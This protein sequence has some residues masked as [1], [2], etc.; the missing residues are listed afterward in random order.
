VHQNFTPRFRTWCA[1]LL[2]CVLPLLAAAPTV[3]QPLAGTTVSPPAGLPSSMLTHDA[4]GRV[5]VAATRIPQPIKMDGRLDDAPYREVPPVSEFIQQ[6]P[7]EGAPSTHKTDVWVL[8]DDTNIYIACRCWDEHPELIVSNDMHRDGGNHGQHDHMVVGLDTFYDG[9]N[10]FQ[11]GVTPAGGMRDATITD[12]RFNADWN[13]VWDGKTSR[14]DRG[15]VAE[16]AI[17]FK[18]LRYKPGRQ[19]TWHIQLRRQIHGQ[20]E[21]VYITPISAAWGISGLN[22]FSLA[23]TLVGLEAP[24]SGRN[25]EI[26]PY[27]ISRITTDLLGRPAVRN[28][29]D[30]DVGVDVKQGVTRGLTADFS[31]NTDFAQVEADE[32]QVNL[33]RFSLLFPEKREFFLEGQGIFQ[34][35]GGGGGDVGGADV[36]TIFYSRR[37]GLSESRAVPVIA[38]GR[39][40]GKAGPWSVGALNMETGEDAAAGAAKT[41]FTVL[42]LRRDILGRS[43][44]GGILTRRSVSTIGPGANDVWGLDGNF[45]FYQNVYFSGYL[46]QSRTENRRGDDLAYRAQFSYTADRYGLALDRLVVDRNFNPEVGFL[47]RENFRRNLVQGRFSPRTAN[48][49]VVRKWTYLSSLEY[50]TDN[51]NRLQSRTLTGLFQSDFHSGDVVS[52]QLQRLFDS[53]PAPFP[54]G[55]VRIPAGG[56][57]FDNMKA[58]YTAGQQHRVSGSSSVEVGSFYGGDKKTV[59]FTGRVNVTLQFGVEPNISFNWGDLPGGRFTTTVV[60]AR[61]TFTMNPR[62][63]TAVLVQYGSSNTSLSTNLRFRW[64]YQPGSELFVVYTEGR[65]TLPPIGAEALQSRGFVVKINRLFRF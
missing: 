7:D 46:A 16:M 29:L 39:L 51:E 8:F 48:N 63:F 19:Q 4:D 43:T 58:I 32:A 36:P 26:K 49:R 31:Y 42:R 53:V 65:S 18:S 2:P 27:A 38:G 5:I 40:T 13:G 61:G 35:G 20:Q 6:E 21:R 52:I 10:G 15:W 33:T 11:F 17:P 54:I 55:D 30:P 59:A 28:E 62:M 22:H 3:A 64:E 56:Y 34:F 60:G 12:E 45:A 50:I 47:R 44:I 1:A 9:R 24:P 25:L 23:A 57:A 14:F 41:N 37:I